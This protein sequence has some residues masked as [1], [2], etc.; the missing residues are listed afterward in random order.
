MAEKRDLKALRADLK[1]ISEN[2]SI[3]LLMELAEEA[4]TPEDA[5]A[6][7]LIWILEQK[8]ATD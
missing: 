2:P 8:Q 6:Q 5:A 3:T 1:H 4:V 7:S